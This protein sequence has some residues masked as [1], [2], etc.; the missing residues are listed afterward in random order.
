MKISTVFRDNLAALLAADGLNPTQ[1]AKAWRTPQ[2][3]LAAYLKGERADVRLAKLAELADA[4]DL[5]PWQLLVE[6]LDPSAPPTIAP[7]SIDEAEL[8]R[9]YRALDEDTRPALLARAKRLALVDKPEDP[10]KLNAA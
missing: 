1:A 10:G 3:T 9:L 5:E 6:G 7:M 8:L 2:R 4:V